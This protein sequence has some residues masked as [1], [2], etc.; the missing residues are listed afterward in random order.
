MEAVLAWVIADEL[1]TTEL[2]GKQ[3]VPVVV[4]GDEIRPP[5]HD[6]ESQ[7]DVIKLSDLV[8]GDRL[9][10]VFI[11][12]GI[13]LDSK[14]RLA[15]LAKEIER[16]DAKYI[17]IVRDQ[18]NPVAETEFSSKMG[19]HGYSIVDISF[20]ELAVFIQKN[21]SMT[22]SETEV[23]ALR[24]RDTFHKFNL[25]AHPTYFAGIS[26]EMLAALLQAN[27]RAELIQLATDGYL[28][29]VVAEDIADI[30]LSRTTRSRYLRTL[31]MSLNIEKATFTQDQ[32][33]KFTREF[34]VESDF[35][36]DPLS[37]I[38]S[39][40][41]KGILHFESEKVRFSLPFIEA[42]L[43]ALGLKQDDEA[44]LRYFNPNDI[45]FDLE[46]F[47]LYAELGPSP[48]VVQFISDQ[49]KSVLEQERDADRADNILL[50]D[51]I[52][53]SLLSHPQHTKGLQ[54]SLTEWTK[55]LRNMNG[56]G[57]EKQK[58]LD[59]ADRVREQAAAR[60]ERSE[61]GSSPTN[62]DWLTVPL[63]TLRLSTV[64]LGSGAEHLNA[65]VKQRLAKDL[66][67]LAEILS[68]KW[69]RRVAAIDFEGIK[70]DLLNS[71]QAKAM[72]VDVPEEKKPEA[73][74][75][76]LS[77]VEV[78][79][80]MFLAAPFRKMLETL[81]ELSRDRV[82]ATS[83]EKAQVGGKIESVFHA[84]WLAD[85]DSK[86]GKSALMAAIKGLP[87]ARFLRYNLAAHFLMRVYWT[88]WKEGHSRYLGSRPA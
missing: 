44:A 19:L 61:K 41:D 84:A 70:K 51:E 10:V 74:K 27:R 73:E 68:D 59:V 71:D 67:Q 45:E 33:I 78:L 17:F 32:L 6:F 58:I 40:V 36:I 28:S 43:L 22:G 46:T 81:C 72:L 29:L 49:L 47:D 3:L 20:M 56:D 50:T 53:P 15:F 25:S 18:S 8:N 38:Y 26:R 80:F 88:H 69:T 86:R 30:T 23:V 42:Y 16:Y 21:F 9:Q 13:P 11:V 54:N 14:T 62:G 1:L 52:N 64:M 82:L 7:F 5:K 83:I 57:R 87:Y 85:V 12:D 35:D 31:A 2:G 48:R 39:F 63:K 66:I 55:K 37:F 60:S 75:L 34:A 77:I 79:E 65:S 24:L 4:T 76:L